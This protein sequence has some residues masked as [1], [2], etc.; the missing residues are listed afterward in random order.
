MLL[1]EGVESYK[2]EGS[3]FMQ[4]LLA[5]TEAKSKVSGRQ[6]KQH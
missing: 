2:R 3:K 4:K 1:Y 5:K 6:G